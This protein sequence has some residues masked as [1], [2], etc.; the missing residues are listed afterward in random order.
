MRCKIVRTQKFMWRNIMKST[1]S[2]KASVLHYSV[3]N[4]RFVS[5]QFFFHSFCCV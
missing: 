4:A 3:D 2:Q 1:K 5:M